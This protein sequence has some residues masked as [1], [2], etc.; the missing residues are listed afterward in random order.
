MFQPQVLMPSIVHV[1]PKNVSMSLLIS[2]VESQNIQLESQ[3]MQFLFQNTQNLQ[4]QALYALSFQIYYI[5][6][7]DYKCH[8]NLRDLCDIILEHC[9]IIVCILEGQTFKICNNCIKICKK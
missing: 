6:L 8:T 9:Y 2:E 5:V 4:F 1:S 7:T 3:N